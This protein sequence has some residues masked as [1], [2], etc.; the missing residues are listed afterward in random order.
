MVGGRPEPNP[1]HKSDLNPN[2]NLVSPP[3]STHAATKTVDYDLN[4]SVGSDMSWEERE[5][6]GEGLSTNELKGL[7]GEK[8][9]ERGKKRERERKKG[10]KKEKEREWKRGKLG[11]TCQGVVST[12]VHQPTT[13]AR[14]QTKH[15]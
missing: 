4:H 9:N 6:C 8:E 13:S 2:P 12:L 15:A 10:E 14:N 7:P 1:N 11:G 3:P 5:G